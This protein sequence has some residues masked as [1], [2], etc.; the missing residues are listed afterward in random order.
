MSSTYNGSPHRFK[1]ALVTF[2]AFQILGPVFAV[3]FSFLYAVSPFT[4][5]SMGDAPLSFAE[6]TH[7]YFNNFKQ[8]FS[9]VIYFAGLPAAIIGLCFAIYRMVFNRLPIWPVVALFLT[10]LL[11]AIN[12]YNDHGAKAFEIDIMIFFTAFMA[13]SCS[14][15]ICQRFLKELAQ[16]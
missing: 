14:W 5:S 2:I 6:V 9:G 13:V 8:T 4:Y 16:G 3:I 15:V 1:L 10:L 12:S 11:L 7:I